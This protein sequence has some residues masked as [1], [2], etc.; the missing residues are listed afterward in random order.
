MINKI[1]S[2]LGVNKVLSPDLIK[3]GIQK[4]DPR[5]RQYF[6]S[7]E[8]AGYPIGASLAFL[9]S[10]LLGEPNNQEVPLARGDVEANK[11]VMQHE[12]FPQR[13]VSAIGRIAGGAALGGLA[14][15]GLGALGKVLPQAG[16]E[17]TPSPEQPQGTSQAE[18]QSQGPLGFQNFLSQNPELGS[19]LDKLMSEGMNIRDAAIKAKESRKFASVVES[20][21]ANVGQ[22]FEDLLEQLLY[23]TNPSGASA[24]QAAP[25]AQGTGNAQSDLINALNEYKA[26]KAGKR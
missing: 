9:K 26:F 3:K 24:Q 4:L 7:A 13:A 25:R 12:A 23:G 20:I 6:Q 16:P 15:A 14:G 5:L 19:Y 11:R 2:L 18:S 22:S 17:G 21:E 1:L 8:K 10:S